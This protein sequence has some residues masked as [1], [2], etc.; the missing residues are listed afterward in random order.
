MTV[1]A[2]HVALF[3]GTP[4]RNIRSPTRAFARSFGVAVFA[5]HS[6]SLVSARRSAK[7]SAAKFSPVTPHFD[8]VGM[9]FWPMLGFVVQ[10]GHYLS[11]A[12]SRSDDGRRPPILSGAPVSGCRYSEPRG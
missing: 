1:N 5:K 2:K 3:P 9:V 12:L 4:T 10:Q 11:E 6:G 7:G 8:S